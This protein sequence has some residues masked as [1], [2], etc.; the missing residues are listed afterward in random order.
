MVDTKWYGS[1]H[2]GTHKKD[3]RFT[4]TDTSGVCKPWR[5]SPEPL[6][7]IVGAPFSAL[8]PFFGEG[9]SEQSGLFLQIS[10][11]APKGRYLPEEGSAAEPKMHVSGGAP[12][13]PALMCSQS[14]WK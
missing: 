4:G 2:K 5:Q 3:A 6:A 14:R 10:Y 9:L 13:R 7:I 12:S 1:C 8:P 11:N